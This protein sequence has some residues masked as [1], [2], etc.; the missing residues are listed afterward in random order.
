MVHADCRATVGTLSNAE[1]QNIK[2][3]KAGR[4]ATRGA[5]RRLGAWR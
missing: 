5:G 2:L 3:G 4:A 1:H